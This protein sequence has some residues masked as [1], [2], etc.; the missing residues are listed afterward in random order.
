MLRY[1]LLL[2]YGPLIFEVIKQGYQ[3]LFNGIEYVHQCSKEQLEYIMT[4]RCE[5]CE[6]RRKL[7]LN[8]FH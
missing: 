1:F 8:T 3:P 6:A 4:C 2:T 7:N 5:L